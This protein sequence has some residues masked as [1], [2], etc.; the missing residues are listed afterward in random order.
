MLARAVVSLMLLA[1]SYWTGVRC[2]L[3]IVASLGGIL[4][5][6]M[7]CLPFLLLWGVTRAIKDGKF[8][9]ENV[10]HVTANEASGL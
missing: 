2:W 1:T 7:G 6:V 3:C 5:F 9:M 4:A 10:P 8:P